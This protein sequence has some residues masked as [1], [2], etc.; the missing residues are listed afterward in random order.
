LAQRRC[1]NT[2]PNIS[3]IANDF[4]AVYQRKTLFD[5]IL[6]ANLIPGESH[7]QHRLVGG[8]IKQSGKCRR[9]YLRGNWK[10][11]CGYN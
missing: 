7:Q 1:C 4:A 3:V 8:D 9:Q 6:N 2:T 5:L 10:Q 11:P